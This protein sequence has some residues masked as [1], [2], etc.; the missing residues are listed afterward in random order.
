MRTLAWLLLGT[1]LIVAACK[2]PTGGHHGNG[3]SGGGGGGASIASVTVTPPDACLNL[4]QTVQ[5]TATVRDSAGAVLAGKTVTWT[6]SDG[7]VVTVD[8]SG[9]VTGVAQGSATV[10]ATSK[11]HSGTAGIALQT[12]T[13]TATLRFLRFRLAV[14]D[15]GAMLQLAGFHWNPVCS[16]TTSALHAM[17]RNGLGA[18]FVVG[19]AGSILQYDTLSAGWSPQASG[20]TS[21]LYGVARAP[22][23][24]LGTLFAVGAG[25]TIL[26]Y[27][28]TSW[29]PQP[30]GTTNALYGVGKVPGLPADF[31]VG[32]AGTILHYDGASWSAQASGTSNDLSSVTVLDS[33]DVY[34]FG[35]GGTI[36]HYDGKSWSQRPIGGITAALRAADVAVDTTTGAVTDFF[37]VGDG[38]TILHSSD[39]VTW[40]AQA[41]GTT[42]DLF[43]VTVNAADNGYAVGALGTVLHFDGNA[44]SKQR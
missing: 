12:G 10:T 23:A 44:W 36:L 28:G 19:G 17:I 37:V 31:A 42:T 4:G 18:I 20:T 30:S 14:G 25:G 34:A 39:G 8:P 38:G 1:G 27:D 3:G 21:A 29:S 13:A 26:H 35:A 22:A 9:L 33:N 32:A 6:T 24:F 15:S 11:G 40:T 41:S 7:A 43:G 5:L 16:G 2:F